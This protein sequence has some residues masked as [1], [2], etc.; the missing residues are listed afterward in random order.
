MLLEFKIN[1]ILP[2]L[3]SE[4]VE[5]LDDTLSTFGENEHGKP[6]KRQISSKQTEK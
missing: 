1:Q 2:D 6:K 5:I 3:V 4:S